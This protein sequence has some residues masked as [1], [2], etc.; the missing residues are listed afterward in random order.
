[1]PLI[2]RKR[3]PVNVCISHPQQPQ[4]RARRTHSNELL[5]GRGQQGRLH[6]GRSGTRCADSPI[7]V[8]PHVGPIPPALFVE[9]L[10]GS[11]Q[12]R[13]E[14]PAHEEAAESPSKLCTEAAT[15]PLHKPPDERGRDG[16]KFVICE[17]PIPAINRSVRTTLKKKTPGKGKGAGGERSAARTP[18]EPS[19]HDGARPGR[20]S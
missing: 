12:V 17:P 13:V 19:R 2:L 18:R 14:L 8:D 15:A 20:R 6:L 3:I 9:V 7:F 5:V 16:R 1:M 10:E 11:I 4:S